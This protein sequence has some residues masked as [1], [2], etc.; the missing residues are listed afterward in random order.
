MGGRIAPDADLT[1]QNNKPV[2]AP[3]SP[4]SLSTHSSS[5]S[6]WPTV[7][8]AIL[9]LSL[10]M[11]AQSRTQDGNL[12]FKTNARIT[13]VSGTFHKSL[14]VRAMQCYDLVVFA[15]IM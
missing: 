7:R 4:D 3:L 12:N 2:F 14:L 6:E 10:V 11:F 15:N 5:V 8:R 13:L 9:C 1:C